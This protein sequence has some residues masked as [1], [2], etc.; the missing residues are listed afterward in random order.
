MN[1]SLRGMSLVLA[2]MVAVLLSLSGLLVYGQLKEAEQIELKAAE[3]AAQEAR[4]SSLIGGAVHDVT[5]LASSFKNVLLRGTSDAARQKH[6]A[7]FD[8]YRADFLAKMDKLAQLEVVNSA[9]ERAALVK[10]WGEQFSTVAQK[11]RDQIQRYD[12]SV[13]D[14]HLQLDKAVSGI[15]RPVVALGAKAEEQVLKAA[16]QASTSMIEQVETLFS[17]LVATVAITS[18]I[19]VAVLLASLLV[20]AGTIKRRLGAEPSDLA[21]MA[22]KMA[23]GDLVLQHGLAPVD[24]SVASAFGRMSESL[25]A[26]VAQIRDSSKGLVS[27]AQD[28][29]TQLRVV[30]LSAQEQSEAGSS[31][32]AGIEELSASVSQLLGV[33]EQSA[34]ASGRSESA[35]R[36]GLTLVELSSR[37]VEDTARGAE[38]LSQTVQ[39]LGEQSQNIGQ[40]IAVIE[41]IAE[42]TN[43]LALN[44]AIEAARAGESGR[45]FAVVADEV[46]RLAERTTESTSE[47]E[48]MVKTIQQGTSGVVD[49]MGAWASK[50][51]QNLVRMGQA[52]QL[53]ADLQ[54]LS[55]DVRVL[56]S[57]VSTSLAEQRTVAQQMSGKVEQLAAGCEEN[58]GCV[59]SIQATIASLTTLSTA[60]EQQAAQF[61]LA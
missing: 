22:N 35:S 56:A 59:Q 53:M 32:A 52:R 55:N 29:Q 27:A 12:P 10:E 14:V 37:E 44:A 24:G 13:P 38:S 60:L 21:A 11:Y 40:I 34:Q 2:A 26:M 46:R 49:E 1:L 47:I 6:T 58:A 28:I 9:P 61:K 15:D 30:D 39:K 4:A 36:E 50:V 17:R 23:S 18:A 16:E 42:Q 31:M 8:K 5:R 45:G 33:A 41:G 43:L 57:E 19:T 25:A 54:N 20:F 48:Q 3:V 7:E 51:S